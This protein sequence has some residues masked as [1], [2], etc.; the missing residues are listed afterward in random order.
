MY[1][2]AKKELQEMLYR[3]IL[4][5]AD[6]V[7]DLLHYRK[8]TVYSMASELKREGKVQSV[9]L[10][11]LRKNHIGYALTRDGA[12]EAARRIG[13]AETFRSHGWKEAPLQLEHFYG[14]NAFFIS[15]I[16]HSLTEPGEGLLEWLG[17]R[18][19]AERY[20]QTQT[21]GRQSRPVK[22][23]GM[24]AYLLPGRGRLVF[25][26][27]Y[28]TG[29]ESTWRLKEKMWN[30]GRLLPTLW[31]K[32][33]A[34]HVLFVTKIASRPGPLI[35]I[36]QALCSGSLSGMRLPNIWVIHEKEWMAKGV[37][38]ALWWGRDG[39]RIRW[40]DMPL[41]SPPVDP[42]LLI[43]GKQPR[44]PSPMQGR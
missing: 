8:K 29:S 34:V 12:K 23:D 5:T 37:E 26:L 21:S 15:L 10:P 9:I 28:D 25:H 1:Y 18:E 41:L 20:V 36:W 38:T 39:Q 2:A 7:A 31:P 43:L 6:Q 35:D 4:L 33:E 17:A 30:Y 13:D 40:K 14:T 3:Y 22:P 11:F 27:E 16:R 24:G 32:V 44:E 42:N 19:A